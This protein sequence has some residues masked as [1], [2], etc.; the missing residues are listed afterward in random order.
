MKYSRHTMLIAFSD[1]LAILTYGKTLSE[2]EAYGNSELTT[3]KIWAGDNKMKFNESK[4]K[5]MIITRKRRRD[6]INIFLNNR[7]LETGTNNVVF[8]N[9]LRQQTFILQAH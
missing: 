2:V 6:K 3:I 7:S 9:T 5:A 4:S 8:G 1:D